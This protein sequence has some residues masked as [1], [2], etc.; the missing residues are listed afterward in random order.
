MSIQRTH[1]S[2]L[3][4][5]L[6]RGGVW[7]FLGKLIT[8]VGTIA[9]A[10][11]LARL[12]SPQDLGGYFLALS[13]SYFIGI[14]SCVGQDQVAIKTIAETIGAARPGNALAI[15]IRTLVI[16]GLGAMGIA[17]VFCFSG[18]GDWLVQD[19]F[20]MSMLSLSVGPIGLWIVAQCLQKVIGDIF[21]GFHDI[22]AAA[23]FS[24]GIIG[25]AVCV[26]I[27]VGYFG[28]LWWGNET[29]NANSAISASV[30]I[31]GLCTLLGSAMLFMKLRLVE[32]TAHDSKSVTSLLR[33][34]FPL[35]VSSMSALWMGHVDIWIIASYL[36]AEKVALYGAVTRLVKFISTASTV[37]DDFISPIIS[38]RYSLGNLR[39]LE[40]VLRMTAGI[41]TVISVPF[42][43]LFV[44][45]G[46]P[47]LTLLYGEFFAAG[48]QVLA[49]LSIAQFVCVFAGSCD[50]TLA[51]TGHGT[52]L[53]RLSLVLAI[54]AS[55]IAVWV[56][57]SHGMLGVAIAFGMATVIQQLGM[58]F[59]VRRLCGIWVFASYRF[60]SK[61][62]D[63]LL[64]S[65]RPH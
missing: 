59:M 2:N 10:A 14:A 46:G 50:H 22:R 51:M 18:V 3:K 38:E 37:V 53:M 20:H 43:V 11:L 12:L 48:A 52:Q 16:A 64:R 13:L 19:F 32:T 65:I 58:L 45:L 44:L 4:T 60:S 62:I 17:G 56:V 36:P 9:L 63:E 33:D 23:Y 30:T 61:A 57:D 6:L 1:D 8:G 21:R 28:Y 34:G 54:A 15:V 55:V 7:S 42:F 49:V 24:G 39:Q 29:I 31:T 41:S 5:R 25:G 26:V 35:W 47:T 40:W 27:H